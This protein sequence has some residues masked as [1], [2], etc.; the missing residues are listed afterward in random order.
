MHMANEKVKRYWLMKSEPSCYSIDDLKKQKV[1]MWDGV[2]N[3]Q[4]RNMMRDDM[5]VGDRVL[6]YH[7]SE[8]PIGVAGVGEIVRRGYPDPTQFDPKADHFD[9][10]AQKE[11]PRWYVVDVGFVEKFDM[12]LTLAEIKNDPL[13]QD[14]VVAQRGS[15]LSVQPVA[16]KHY[17]RIISLMRG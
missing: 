15:R 12:I 7:S 2:R 1:G 6:F 8:A 5:H 13:L 11:N 16:K 10:S 14:M 3:Y 4:A 9:P 17:E